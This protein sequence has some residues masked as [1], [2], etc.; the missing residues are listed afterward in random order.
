MAMQPQVSGINENTEA[1]RLH[2]GLLRCFPQLLV[3]LTHLQAHLQASLLL[4]PKLAHL[5]GT[6][7][8]RK[9]ELRSGYFRLARISVLSNEVAGQ[10]REI[11]V[12]HGPS[13]SL[14]G[15]DHFTGVSK[16]IAH[17]ISRFLTRGYS[18]LNGTFKVLPFLPR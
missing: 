3:A 18:P 12:L 13:G 5:V 16:M 8:Y 2:P 7:A 17:N 14:A 11:V 1:F 15:S 6:G 10:T 4:F 9:I